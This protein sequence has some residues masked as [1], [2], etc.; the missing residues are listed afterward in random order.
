MTT[1][2]LTALCPVCNKPLQRR[3]YLLDE[4][5]PHYACWTC[6]NAYLEDDPQI[7]AA[8]SPATGGHEGSNAGTS[9][10]S[11]AAHFQARVESP[12]A[13]RGAD[14]SREGWGCVPSLPHLF[15]APPAQGA[16][17]G[18]SATAP[19]APID[20]GRT[21]SIHPLSKTSGD[22]LASAITEP[23]PITRVRDRINNRLTGGHLHD[24]HRDSCAECSICGKANYLTAH[25]RRCNCCE[26][27]PGSYVM[28]AEL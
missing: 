2:T 10:L 3:D 16:E 14:S 24:W 7:W 13:D 27:E 19:S 5:L 22:S 11:A 4:S 23:S 28:G 17:G 20:A 18:K 21:R 15:G 26:P 12:F 6:W 1:T 9:V 8:A 25:L